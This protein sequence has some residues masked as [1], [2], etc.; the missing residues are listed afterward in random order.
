MVSIKNMLANNHGIT[1]VLFAYLVVFIMVCISIIS[2]SKSFSVK[3]YNDNFHWPE[4]KVPSTQEKMST[5]DG[6]HYLFLS[7]NGYLKDQ[8]SNAF[9]P[10]WPM[11]IYAASIFSGLKPLY[12]GLLMAKKSFCRLNNK[13]VQKHI[14]QIG[15]A[16]RALQANFGPVFW[17]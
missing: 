13:R 8:P 9:Y 11:T 17:L 5:W 2:F 14:W 12:A 3:S 1:N 16:C 6:E 15:I 10:L 7:Q 4:N